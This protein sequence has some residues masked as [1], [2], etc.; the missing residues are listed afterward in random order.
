MRRW[1]PL[2]LAV[3]LLVT[4]LTSPALARQDD[5]ADHAG[6]PSAA[7]VVDLAARHASGTAWIPDE[8]PMRG[9]HR[10]LGQAWT[11]MIHGQGVVQG[12]AGSGDRGDRQFGGTSWI[13]LM[14]SRDLAGGAVT[15]RTMIS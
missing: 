7:P 10:P 14:L 2:G 1:K 12:L 6:A 3:V 15:A 5:H 4:L 9:T 11:L 8:T 13:M